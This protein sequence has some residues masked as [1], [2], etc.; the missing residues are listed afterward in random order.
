MRVEHL[1]IDGSIIA[2]EAEADL[3][4]KATATGWAI[5]PSL[6]RS[7]P[8]TISPPGHSAAVEQA[9]RSSIER[10]AILSTEEY[11]LK[12][13]TLRLA[14][15]QLPTATEGTR[16]LTVGAWEGETGCLSTSLR[17]RERDRLVE[18]FDTLDFS[19]RRGGLAIDSPIV[20]QPRP[21][22]I[23]KEIPD[24]GILSVR[25]AIASELERV[26]KA[27]GFATDFGELFRI[28]KTSNALLLV[29]RSAVVTV[30]PI[31]RREGHE[32]LAIVRTLRVEWTPRGTAAVVH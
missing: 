19:Q 28:R 10:V 20:P 23:I 31:G 8:F 29:T 2:F 1:A 14:E 21:P 18:V 24:V 17:G 4:T 5:V 7:H 9:V 27:R 22:E 6:M 32:L 15:I 3:S 26:P 13:G 12:N 25:P 16:E 30:N 11:H